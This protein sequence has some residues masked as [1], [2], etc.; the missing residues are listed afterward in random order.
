M[1]GGQFGQGRGGQV[2]RV[3]RQLRVG[4]VT[5]QAAHSKG[6]A[7]GATAAVLDHVA[8]QGGARRL[9]DNAPVQAL[10][11]R[12]QALDYGL[13]AVMGRAF[14]VAGDQEGDAALVRRV[15]TDET[16]NGDD[17]RRQAA[18]HVSGA[19]A[20]EH[21]L[22]VDAYVEG[23]ILP[24]LQRAGGHYVGVAGKAQHRAVSAMQGP[25][26]VHVLD[27]HR[28]DGKAQGLQATHH[29]RLAVGIQWGDRRATDQV[30]GQFQGGGEGGHDDSAVSNGEK[31]AMVKQNGGQLAAVCTV[32]Q[33]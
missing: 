7:E 1:L 29:Q 31:A 17:H 3:L 21:A 30:A 10:V 4:H 28:F 8:D 18:F 24:S 11:A 33:A 5:L 14:F 2:D 19:T 23:L 22:L 9:A 20:A 26:I 27:A 13:G 12:F 25:E 16:L 6:G 32:A 15:L